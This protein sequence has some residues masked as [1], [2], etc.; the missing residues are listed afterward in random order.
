MVTQQI[1][2]CNAIQQ[3]HRTSSCRTHGTWPS[4]EPCAAS[5]VSGFRWPI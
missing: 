2:L 4:M 3:Y 5:I 1:L